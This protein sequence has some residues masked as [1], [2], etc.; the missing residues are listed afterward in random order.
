MKIEVA[1]VGF[2]TF[3]SGCAPSHSVWLDGM[4]NLAGTRLDQHYW[5]PLCKVDCLVR[6]WSPASKRKN[7]FDIVK[8]EGTNY[9]YFVTWLPGC[10][11]SVLVDPGGVILSWQYEVASDDKCIVW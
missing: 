4:D 11:Y 10:Q 8:A 3:L 9:R 1:F 2:V 5:P 6:L 7:E